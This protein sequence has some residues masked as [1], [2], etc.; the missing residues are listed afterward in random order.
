[1]FICRRLSSIAMGLAPCTPTLALA[2]N[3]AGH[4]ISQRVLLISINGMHA[5]DFQ[6]CAAANTCPP[7]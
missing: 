4:P 5:L 2:Q 1:M 6:N 7:T 3:G